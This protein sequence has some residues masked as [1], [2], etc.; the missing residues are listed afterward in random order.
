MISEEKI[1]YFFFRFKK[2]S[3]VMRTLLLAPDEKYWD[4]KEIFPYISFSKVTMNERSTACGL[5]IN[6]L[7][8]NAWKTQ[9][10]VAVNFIFSKD[11]EEGRVI[12]S[13]Y[14]ASG[15]LQVEYVKRK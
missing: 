9:L 11:A 3:Y 12:H 7:N 15:D 5:I 6:H 1:K 2:Q 13:S 8:S 10:T 4:Y 14:K